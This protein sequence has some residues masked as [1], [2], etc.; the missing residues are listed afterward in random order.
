MYNTLKN[1]LILKPWRH[2][3]N[4]QPAKKKRK[5]TILQGKQMLAFIY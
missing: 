3:K 1:N 2:A 4:F 5:D